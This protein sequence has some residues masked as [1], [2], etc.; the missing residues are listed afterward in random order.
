MTK[1][2]ASKLHYGTINKLFFASIAAIIGLI[3]YLFDNVKSLEPF[4][5]YLSLA[6][7][8]VLICGLYTMYVRMKGI[9]TES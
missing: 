1:K 3:H 6:T 9:L 5:I 8:V 4:I 2:E 7:V